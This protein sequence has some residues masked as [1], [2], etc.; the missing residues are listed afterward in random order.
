MNYIQTH[1]ELD[2]KWY[3]GNPPLPKAIFLRYTNFLVKKIESYMFILNSL[4]SNHIDSFLTI[5]KISVP[6]KYMITRLVSLYGI[7]PTFSSYKELEYLTHFK[8]RQAREHLKEAEKAK[9]IIRTTGTK[10]ESGKKIGNARILQIQLPNYLL[11]QNESELYAMDILYHAYF[12]NLQLSKKI[13]IQI[14]LEH[15]DLTPPQIYKT[16]DSLLASKDL[17]ILS[18][19]NNTILIPTITSLYP[20][21]CKTI[22]SIEEQEQ[23]QEQELYDFF[24]YISLCFPTEKHFQMS[25]YL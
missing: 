17:S 3:G 14:L 8:E 13:L 9:I 10:E 2:V 11:K 24:R 15:T 7:A 18:K 12:R 5:I 21:K 25:Q 6:C 4:Q 1:I 22:L 16:I 19:N 23:E 20:K